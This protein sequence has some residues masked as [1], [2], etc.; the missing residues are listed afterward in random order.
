MEPHLSLRISPKSI[1]VVDQRFAIGQVEASREYWDWVGIEIIT[2][3]LEVT[4]ALSDESMQV[5]SAIVTK[6]EGERSAKFALK[7]IR[8]IMDG[9]YPELGPYL[10][11]YTAMSI[12]NQYR[13]L[14]TESVLAERLPAME[15]SLAEVTA[16]LAKRG[17]RP[18]SFEHP[19]HP[20][21]KPRSFCQSWKKVFIA[22]RE[23]SNPALA[24]STA[25]R[26]FLELN[27]DGEGQIFGGELIVEG[28]SPPPPWVE[29]LLN[30]LATGST[31]DDG[32]IF[33]NT[34]FIR[35]RQSSNGLRV[36]FAP[37]C[38]SRNRRIGQSL[39]VQEPYLPFIHD[40]VTMTVSYCDWKD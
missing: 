31:K 34:Y 19:R 39:K 4:A 14:I 24:S 17:W 15:G 37:V 32:K 29:P 1:H 9:E 6:W 33:G 23:E 12:R 10:A 28:G 8:R 25:C 38:Q 30:M 36:E 22:N 5:Y 18:P 16:Y 27:V 26:A 35:R 13:R 7:Q 21:W 40:F 2:Q 3:E 20:G 11:K